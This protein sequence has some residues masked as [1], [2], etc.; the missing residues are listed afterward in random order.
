VKNLEHGRYR[1]G[2][3][4]VSKPHEDHDLREACQLVETGFEYITEIG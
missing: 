2:A 3:R 4:R 1:M